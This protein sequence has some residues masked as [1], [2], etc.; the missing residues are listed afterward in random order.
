MLQ[1]EKKKERV[2]YLESQFSRL[3]LMIGKEGLKKLK[4]SKVAVFGLGGVGSYVAE[5]LARSAVG[6]LILIDGDAYEPSNLNRQLYADMDTLGR[7][8]AEAAR[9]RILKINPDCRVT[10]CNTFFTPETSRYFDFDYDYIADAIDSVTDK[11]ALIERAY[12]EN[13]PIISSMGTGNKMN[14]TELEVAD[15]KDTSMCPLARVMRKEL[16]KR[17]I[18]SLKVVYSKE[19]PLPTR[20]DVTVYDEEKTGLCTGNCPDSP[21]TGHKRLPPGSNAFVPPAAGLIMAG[22][23]VKALL[24]K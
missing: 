21:G 2:F 5:A 15:L 8:K 22:E 18:E 1:L 24:I 19:K 9:E 10:A 12:I 7:F 20:E 16:R 11:I 6:E 3:E 4:G 17:N 14:P 13:V 23:I